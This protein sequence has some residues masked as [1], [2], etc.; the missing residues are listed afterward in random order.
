MPRSMLTL[1][2]RTFI[3][4]EHISILLSALSLS[5]NNA[6]GAGDSVARALGI[7]YTLV[8]VFAG[9]WGWWMYVVRSRMIKERSGKDLDN[10]VG[11]IIVCIAL[12]VALCLNFGFK[13][14]APS[15]YCCRQ[16]ADHVISIMHL[17]TA[18][19]LL[20]HLPNSKVRS[21]RSSSMQMSCSK[22]RAPGC[23]HNSSP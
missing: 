10:V 6:A 4:W 15:L 9:V 11:P 21:S 14:G 19:S 1:V 16:L 7:I 2:F 20:S 8:A 18:P 23:L 5:L 12:V 22:V 13:V 17:S 3:K